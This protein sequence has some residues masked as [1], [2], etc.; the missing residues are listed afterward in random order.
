MANS[1]IAPYI[2]RARASLAVLETYAQEQVDA[3]VKAAC[4]AFKAHAEEL[5]REVVEETGLGRYDDKLVKNTGTPDA[6]WYSLKG[7]KSVGIIG[8]DPGKGLIY[9]AKPKGVVSVIAPTTNPNITALCNSVFAIKGRNV[10]IIAPHPR[11]KKTTA[12]TVRIMNDAIMRLGAPAHVLQV[13]EEPSI[14]LTQ[15][16]MRASDVIVAT[17]GAAMVRAAYA[18]G[19]PAFGV[20]PGNVQT[21]V[22]EGFD[23][24]EA[25]QQIVEGRAFDN[26]LICAGN[27]SVI[28][29]AA[30]KQL[31]VAALRKS[32]AY[33]TDNAEEIEKFRST[34]FHEGTIS[35]FVVGLSALSIAE[36]AGVRVPETTKVIALPV[37]KI[38]YEEVLCGEKMCP[39]LAV[40]AYEGGFENGVEI[41]RQNLLYQG[42]GHSAVVHTHDAAKAEYAGVTLPVSRLL[43]NQPGIFAANPALCNGFNPT[44]T[45]GCGS[46]GN[47]SISENLTYEHLIN[48]SRIGTMLAPNDVPRPEDIWA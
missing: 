48:I 21:V 15:E 6:M 4:T 7:K 38:G 36:L 12:H 32:G 34:L 41:A 16:L 10:C 23:M 35:R 45:L 37:E 26:G 43:V 39:V 42:V 20:G 24:E 14:E 18:S 30:Q 11:A 28:V 19:H 29:P 1:I 8:R 44:T 9:V 47:N 25:A 40:I 3:L 27:Q 5:S 46:W 31:M 17:G 33:Y 22:D 2:E 13:I